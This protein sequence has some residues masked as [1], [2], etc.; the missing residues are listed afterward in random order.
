MRGWRLRPLRGTRENCHHSAQGYQSVLAQLRP[1]QDSSN[2]LTRAQQGTLGMRDV[3]LAAFRRC[4]QARWRFI[5]PRGG[6]VRTRRQSS[7]RAPLVVRSD[8]LVSRRVWGSVGER[9]ILPLS[10]TTDQPWPGR[11][12]ALASDRV[13]ASVIAR[14]DDG[15]RSTSAVETRSSVGAAPPRSA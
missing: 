5:E 10:R 11:N 14:P 12:A 3:A 6:D 8:I 13:G 1:T 2:R 15:H 4:R 9:A 7:S